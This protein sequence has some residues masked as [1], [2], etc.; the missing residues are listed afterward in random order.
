MSNSSEMF[1]IWILFIFNVLQVRF[2][3]QWW[4]IPDIKFWTRSVLDPVPNCVVALERILCDGHSGHEEGELCPCSLLAQ[5]QMLA[6]YRISLTIFSIP[7]Y[8]AFFLPYWKTCPWKLQKLWQ[9]GGCINSIILV[10]P[11]G[12][13][14]C[15]I[16]A[17]QRRLGM[18]I[19]TFGGLL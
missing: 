14:L 18:N 10:N 19:R 5:A 3:G 13:H 7:L 11:I 4:S 9:Q 17:W 12:Q 6:K 8:T 16:K 2:T 1:F 15:C